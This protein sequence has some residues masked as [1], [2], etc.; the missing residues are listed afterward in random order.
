[1]AK[2]LTVEELA[3]RQARQLEDFKRKQAEAEIEKASKQLRREVETKKKLFSSFLKR[4]RLEI[5][6]S[7]LVYA[8]SGADGSWRRVLALGELPDPESFMRGTAVKDGSESEIP[9]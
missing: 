9:E 6:G 7:D 2:R 1:M 8:P 5:R 4:H 3:A